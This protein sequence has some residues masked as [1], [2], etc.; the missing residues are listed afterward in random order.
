MN[1]VGDRYD[2]FGTEMQI[3]QYLLSFSAMHFVGREIGDGFFLRGDAGLAWMAVDST[4]GNAESDMGVG[5][6]LGCGYGIPVTPGTRI[7]LNLNYA[8]R[9]VEGDTIKTVNVSV[10]GLF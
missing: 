7:L 9:K 1:A 10:G 5:I 2:L 4:S 8:I 6:L 3:N